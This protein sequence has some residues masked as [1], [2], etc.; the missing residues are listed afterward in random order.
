MITSS[1]LKYRQLLSSDENESLTMAQNGEVMVYITGAALSLKEAKER[2]LYQLSVNKEYKDL[3]FIRAE[4]LDTGE[5][6][7]YVKMTPLNSNELEIGYAIL[8]KF[9]GKGYASEM[10]V[11]MEDF[12]A[13]LKSF[14]KLVGI[15]DTANKPSIKVLLKRNFTLQKENNKK[16]YYIKHLH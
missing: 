1:R 2:F 11:A 14:D 7:G 13:T 16:S 9:W 8:P 4:S 5:F 10:L 15:A 3:G 6:I 12:A